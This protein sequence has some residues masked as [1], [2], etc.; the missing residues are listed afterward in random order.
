MK[1][2]KCNTSIKKINIR[3]NVGFEVVVNIFFFLKWYVFFERIGSGFNPENNKNMIFTI[4]FF[5]QMLKS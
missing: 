2:S 5:E 3:E 4:Y 1:I